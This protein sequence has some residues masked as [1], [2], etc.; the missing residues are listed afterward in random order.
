MASATIAGLKK[1]LI[2]AI[3]GAN[4]GSFGSAISMA[5][6]VMTITGLYFQLLAS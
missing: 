2:N 3:L 4:D 1:Q 6:E 5:I